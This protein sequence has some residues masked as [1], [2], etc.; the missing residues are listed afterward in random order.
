MD[1]VLVVGAGP[2][3]LTAAIELAR[4]GVRVRVL[5]AADGPHRGS[6]GKGMQP[7]TLE[8]LDAMGVADRLVSLGAFELAIRRHGADGTAEDV[9]LNRAE[10]DPTTPWARSLIIPQWRTEQVL[11]ERLAEE[12]VEIEY[13]RHVTGLEQDDDGVRVALEDGGT[14]AASWVVGADGGSSTVR[15]ELGIGFLGETHEEV[16]LL[17]GDVELDGLDRDHWHMWSEPGPLVGSGAMYFAL[18]PLP[19]TPTWQVQIAHSDPSVR[20]SEPVLRELIDALAPRIRVRRVETCGDWR[21]NVRM[22]DDYRVGRVLLAGDAAH[23]HSPAGGQGMNTGISD[24]VNLGWKLAAV[25][26][27]RAEESLLDTYT[28]ERLPVAAGVLGLSGQLTRRQFWHRTPE[29]VRDTAGFATNYRGGPLAVADDDG[30]GPRPGD[31]AP[32]APLVVDGAATDLFAERRAAD[33]T[34]LAF[35][36]PAP[37]PELPGTV[38][39]LDADAI[40]A[41][42]VLREAY[43]ASDGDVIVIRPDGFVWS[44][45]AAALVSTN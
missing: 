31:R 40:A 6:R 23:V 43:G 37:A 5:D 38:Q 32:D 25:A 30:P 13:G 36:G 18:C 9:V 35:G 16:R 44:R 45:C 27:G 20:S 10:P 8:L 41:D 34:V 2:T 21:L 12:G 29:Q 17:L 15:R 39:V 26:A 7:R 4:R 22:V 33:W 24:A 11:R 14:V 3:G 42:G 19:A 1:D 28:A